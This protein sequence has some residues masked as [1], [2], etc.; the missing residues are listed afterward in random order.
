MWEDNVFVKICVIICFYVWLNSVLGSNMHL[1]WFVH[2][3]F[4]HFLEN[5]CVICY[6][7]NENYVS[8]YVL[9]ICILHI[10][11]MWIFHYGR[12]QI[13]FVHTYVL[14]EENCDG[15]ELGEC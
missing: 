13:M 4:K 9:H 2:I 15:H 8:I 14:C 1:Y 3:E 12:F 6:Y 7:I 5:V 11:I 10:C